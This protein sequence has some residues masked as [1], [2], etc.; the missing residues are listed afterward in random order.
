DDFTAS[1][2]DRF[3]EP[4]QEWAYVSIDT[5]VIGLVI[6]GATGRPIADLLSD[7]IIALLGQERDGYYI[8]DGSGV[9]FVLG[10]LNLTTRD[11]ARFG[12]MIEQDGRFNGQQIVPADWIAVSTAASAPTPPGQTGYGYQWWVP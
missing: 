5:H 11:Y 10:G 1:F 6:R 2:V 9:A 4:G 12:L 7:K 8:T 3:A